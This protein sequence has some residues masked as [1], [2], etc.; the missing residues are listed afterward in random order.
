MRFR[1]FFQSLPK[2]HL[3]LHAGGLF[4]ALMMTSCAVFRTSEA[5]SRSNNKRPVAKAPA[6]K[7]PLAVKP[8]G[9]YAN[10]VRDVVNTARTFTGTPYRSGGNDRRGIDCSGL[11]ASVYSEV[12]LKVPRISW[13][14]AEFGTEVEEVHDIKAGDWIFYVPDAGKAGYVSHVGIV[15]EVRGKNEI[16]FI[17]ASSSKGVRED[18]L[19]SKYFKNRFVKAIRPF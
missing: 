4:I 2:Q 5:P 17:H 9:A 7:R 3:I 8:K 6:S 12:G 19:Y 18:N 1:L 16:L 15:T 11:V 14:Q 10:Y 13:Q